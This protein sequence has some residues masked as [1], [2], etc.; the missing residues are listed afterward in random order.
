MAD[1]TRGVAAHS[2]YPERGVNAIYA[3]GMCW[4]GLRDMGTL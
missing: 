2:A 1:A 3:M 4:T